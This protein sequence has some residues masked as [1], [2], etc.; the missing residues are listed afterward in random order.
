MNIKNA[1]NIKSL[2]IKFS[3]KLNSSFLEIKCLKNGLKCDLIR[4][5]ERPENLVII[6]T[7]YCPNGVYI[8]EDIKQNLLLH[9][10]LVIQ[11]LVLQTDR[12][13]VTLG[14]IFDW[15]KNMAILDSY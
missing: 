1:L 14:P 4:Q 13:S 12:C 2:N 5:L 6:R 11:F 15:D 9:Y 3:N 10:D 8:H 7:Q